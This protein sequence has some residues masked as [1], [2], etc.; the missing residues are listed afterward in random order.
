M[1]RAQR[2]AVDEFSWRRGEN[3]LARPMAGFAQKNIP[4]DLRTPDFIGP[5][6]FSC[7]RSPDTQ[8]RFGRFV[9]DKLSGC[10][11]HIEHIVSVHDLF[12]ELSWSVRGFGVLKLEVSKP[13]NLEVLD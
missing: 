3:A 13:K 5:N 12:R 1:I 10:G 6:E 11:T 9:D 2:A 4:P 8:T 7:G